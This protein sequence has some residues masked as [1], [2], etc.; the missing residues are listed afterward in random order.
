MS[1]EPKNGPTPSEVLSAFP[2][3]LPCHSS[4][5]LWELTIRVS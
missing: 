1:D 3:T 5:V 2:S 4:F